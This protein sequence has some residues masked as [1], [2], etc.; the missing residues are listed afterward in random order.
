MHWSS[1]KI[2]LF[3]KWKNGA[4]STCSMFECAQLLL[5]ANGEKVIVS[6]TWK[7]KQAGKM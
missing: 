2:K 6:L 7:S 5:E 3:F 1:D 4:F